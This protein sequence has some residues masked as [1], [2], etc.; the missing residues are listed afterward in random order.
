MWWQ[1]SHTLNLCLLSNS[2]CVSDSV[3]FTDT[4]IATYEN[5]GEC[6][7]VP[8]ERKICAVLVLC[9]ALAGH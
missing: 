5:I 6:V 8:E 1:S 9:V 3:K 7:S 4:T 2:W